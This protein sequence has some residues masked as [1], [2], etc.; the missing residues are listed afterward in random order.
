MRE[1][2]SS[3]R[4]WPLIGHSTLAGSQSVAP[5]RT[6]THPRCRRRCGGHR[7]RRCGGAALSVAGGAGL[8]LAERHA[9]HRS[10]GF[11]WHE[12][13]VGV[14]R[15]R[16]RG[17]AHACLHGLRSR[18][19]ARRPCATSVPQPVKI[20]AP[21]VRVVG[22]QKVRAFAGGALRCAR[23]GVGKPGLPRNLEVISKQVRRGFVVERPKQGGAGRQ[24]VGVRRKFRGERRRQV[25]LYAVAADVAQRAPGELVRDLGQANQDIVGVLAGASGRQLACPVSL[26]VARQRGRTVSVQLGAA[27]G[28]HEPFALKSCPLCPLLEYALGV[29]LGRGPGRAFAAPPPAVEPRC[30]RRRRPRFLPNPRWRVATGGFVICHGPT[31]AKN[32]SPPG[33]HRPCRAPGTTRSHTPGR[34]AP[35]ARRSRPRCSRSR[36]AHGARP[37]R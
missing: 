11:V 25:L 35:A 24:R 18:R 36:A 37:A 34:P 7:S 13:S 8:G 16:D 6:I 26:Q 5:N 33:D 21:T 19:V 12:V 3:S 2:G 32:A 17:V 29:A 31:A 23:P 15:Q 4:S 1:G 28:L 9:L 14:E 10:Q 20:H 30:L 22:Q 27:L